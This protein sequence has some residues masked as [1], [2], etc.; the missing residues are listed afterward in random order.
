MAHAEVNAVNDVPFDFHHNN[1]NSILVSLEPCFHVGQTNPCVDLIL[2][3][4]FKKVSI[5]TIDPN[6]KVSGKSIDKLISNQVKVEYRHNYYNTLD[7]HENYHFEKTLAPFFINIKSQRPFIILK[8]AESQ[9][10]FIG[11]ENERV[12]ISNDYSKRLV[13]KWRSESDAILVGTNTAQ[14]DNPALNNRFYYGKSPK[15]VVFDKNLNLDPKLHLFDNTVQTFVFTEKERACIEENIN[16][17]FVQL[18]FDEHFLPRMLDVLFKEKIGILLVEGGEKVL[19]SFI[20]SGLWD[21]AYVIKSTKKMDETMPQTPPILRGGIK[22][23]F[24]PVSFFSHSEKLD[25]NT[26]HYFKNKEEYS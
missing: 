11:I 6:P 24:I 26:I 23:P 3:K 10:G 15:R 9:D 21:R 22:A 16:T 13:H 17:K 5:A 4:G 1:N 20:K 14:I 7:N 8:W 25:D 12:Q 2:D 19:T 18:P